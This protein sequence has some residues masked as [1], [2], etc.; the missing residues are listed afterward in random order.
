MNNDI[1]NNIYNIHNKNPNMFYAK[2]NELR[3]RLLSGTDF[4]VYARG[5]NF[6][7]SRVPHRIE[8]TFLHHLQLSQF[9]DLP[10]P[11]LAYTI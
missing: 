9:Y 7:T 4:I 8:P 3:Y 2:I 10:R 5:D 6:G 1:K 11:H